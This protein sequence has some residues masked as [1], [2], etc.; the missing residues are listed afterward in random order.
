MRLTDE[1]LKASDN[2]TAETIGKALILSAAGRFGLFPSPCPFQVSLNI[3]KDF[4]SV[5]SLCCLA[6]TKGGHLIDVKYDTRYSN[7]FET[8]IPIPNDSETSD[9]FLTINIHPDQWKETAANY[10]EPEYSFNLI[11]ANSPI[12]DNALPIAHIVGSKYSGWQIDE[13]DFVPPCLFVSSHRKFED[14]LVRFQDAIAN[15]DSKTRSV[16]HS[17]GHDAICIFWPL[18]QQIRI[19]ID[20]E[21]DLLT[22][23]EL[24]GH[25]QKIVCAFTTACELDDHLILSDADAFHNY[26]SEPY[27]YQDVY[28]RIREGL[29]I[30]FSITE[31]ISKME[32]REEPPKPNMAAPY[33]SDDQLY[34][35]CHYKT[36]KRPVVNPVAGATVYYSTNGD[37]P[38]Q[39][40][41]S[42]VMLAI[43]NNFNTK[44]TEEDDQ[45]IEIKLKSVLNGVSSE[46][47]TFMVIFHKDFKAWNLND[48]LRQYSLIVS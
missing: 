7:S 22:P 17:Q 19:T 34:Q 2:A 10:E 12:P 4:V 40:L 33:I 36:V 29:D 27:N 3:A 32:V 23:M 21:R 14:L 46:V 44:K 43:D 37:E 8:H 28:K 48:E 41:A 24:L 18:I 16:L 9:W 25:V 13:V 39:K 30:C 45:T 42:G 20:K 38:K 35:N 47:N 11:T 5:E 15:I 26:V 6:V 31:K 1:I